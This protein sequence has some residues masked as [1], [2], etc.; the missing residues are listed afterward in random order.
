M[1]VKLCYVEQVFCAKVEGVCVPYL[2]PCCAMSIARRTGT[3]EPPS[4]TLRTSIDLR[5]GL[6]LPCL[7]SMGESTRFLGGSAE[8]EQTIQ[9]E[10]G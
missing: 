10:Q 8:E 7:L 3:G 9:A 1:W 4:V 2:C 6:L 5:S